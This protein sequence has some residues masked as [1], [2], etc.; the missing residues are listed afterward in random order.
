[1]KKH[2]ISLMIL[3]MLVSSSLVGVSNQV[4]DDSSVVQEDSYQY[5]TDWS[6]H[7]TNETLR[8]EINEPF[9]GNVESVSEPSLMTG[10]MD[11]PWPMFGHDVVHTCRSTISTINITGTE[12]W[13]KSEGRTGS[14]YGTPIIDNNSIL[15]FGTTGS[16][17]SLYAFYPNGTKK[18]RYI[19]DGAVW[20]TPAITEDGTII[21]PTWGGDS[22]V[23]AVYPNGTVKWTYRDGSETHSLSS[24]A[25]GSDGT[26]Y[27]GSDYY[28]TYNIYAI[29]AN[30]TLRW[31]YSTGFITNGAPAIGSDGTV[32]IGS[33][34]HHLYAMNPNGTLRWWFDAGSDI[35]GAAT[36][37][38][39]GT[40]YIPAFN[41]YFYALA[42]NGTLL[43]Q[44]YTGDSVAAAG[45]ALATD[46]TI[47]VGTE[48]LR[49]YN[50]NGTLRWSVEL[51]GDVY[52][53]VPAVSADGTI[54][55]SAGSCLVAINPE[56]TERW[57]KEI[58]NE[59][60]R[61]SP[62]IG[63]DDRVY[64][65]SNDHSNNWYIHA[66]G[67]GPLQAEAQ[68]PYTNMVLYPVQFAGIAFGG[69]LPYSY[70][71][72]FGDGN[73]STEI[74]PIHSYS[75]P[76]NYTATFTVTDNEGNISTD[77][78]LV[79]I[80]PPKPTVAIMKP[81][82]GIYIGDSRI[83]PFFKPFIIGQITIQVDA[84][85]EPYGI[86]RVEFYIDG[87][88]Q[89]TVTEIPYQWTWSTK[90]FFKHYIEVWAYDTSGKCSMASIDVS[91]FF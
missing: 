44:G 1:M 91:K 49:A 76:G 16:D 17:S 62:S 73:T 59:Q 69:T 85:Q 79:T 40:I 82:N 58:S 41:D 33:G 71:W 42:P 30:G 50:P 36:I 43:W 53:T 39:D 55:V 29:N 47:Y 24:P 51:P 32:Y 38:P 6:V 18:W 2:L 11:S 70:Q 19:S 57:S 52:G 86:A 23:H 64:V 83:L 12:I 87:E 8:E 77:N 45:L 4:T 25:I 13:R 27:F 21:F 28:P 67:L 56:G 66:F 3:F 89:A 9:Y 34:D 10:P 90:A 61:S 22:A 78:A 20:A 68:G 75:V 15:Y 5:M 26:I 46:G 37:T 60:I 88:I 14:F 35:K 54:Y 63:P 80:T 74:N 81:V 72:D 7:L 84:T 31:K 48:K 65:G